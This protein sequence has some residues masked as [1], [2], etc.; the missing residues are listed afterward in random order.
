MIWRFLMVYRRTMKRNFNA[1][2]TA[3]NALG[4][5]KILAKRKEPN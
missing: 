5:A 4:L 1:T 2:K 3:Q